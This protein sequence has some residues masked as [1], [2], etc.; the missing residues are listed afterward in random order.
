MFVFYHSFPSLWEFIFPCFENGMDFCFTRNIWKTHNFE[1]FVFSHT[2]PVLW[3]FTFAMFWELHGFLLHLKYLRNP[4]NCNVCVF[5]YFS[6]TMETHFSHILGIA[7][8]SASNEKSKKP[9]TLKCLRFPYS[10]L[11]IWIH[12][13]HILDIA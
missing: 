3:E 5:P 11:T 7:W 1:M 10:F 9:L 13:F 8:I 4:W 2:F 12:F 6:C